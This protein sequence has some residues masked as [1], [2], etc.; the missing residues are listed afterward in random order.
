[1]ILKVHW[2]RL[3]DADGETC[4]RCGGTQEE[5][6]QAV[7]TLKTSLR[8]LGIQVAFE[9]TELSPEECA[10]D[11]MES[12]RIWMADHPLEEWLGGEVGASLCGSCCSQLGETV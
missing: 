6:R 5:L 10:K 11:I 7:E 4:D 1:M 2:Q 12:N 3:V 8:P 9:T